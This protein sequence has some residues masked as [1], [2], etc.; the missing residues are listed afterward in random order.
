M[1]SSLDHLSY[2][3]KLRELGLFT[4]RIGGSREILCVQIPEGWVE[5]KDKVRLFQWCS[6]LGREAMGT[7]GNE[8]GAI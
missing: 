6:A 1:F 2:N 7:R 4:L 5:K 3:G 8:G